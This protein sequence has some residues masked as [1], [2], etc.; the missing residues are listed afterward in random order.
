VILLLRK[1]LLDGCQEIGITLKEEQIESFMTYLTFLQQK[2]QEMNLTA[3]Q[4]GEE[5]IIKHFLDS[6]TSL[7][8]LELQP[9]AKLID[10]GT[11]AGFPGVPLKIVFPELQLSLL[12]SLK[13]R[14]G[15]LEDLCLKLRLKGVE[16]IHGRA[17]DFGQNTA[18]R[19][20]FDYVV[21]RAV[22]ELGVL[23]E[24]CLPLVKVGGH[25]LALKGPLA[26]EELT[27]GKKALQILGGEVEKVITL[28]LPLREDK[29]NLVLIKKNKITPKQYPRKAGTPQKKPLE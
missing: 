25:F 5:I 27:K 21:S 9:G 10:I 14:V 3:I 2:S 11:G 8:A 12:D 4:E 23:A 15:F 24:Y 19:E 28:N 16:F 29:R 17:E 1:L 22:A 18:Y 20:K 6:L 26:G 13:K 7:K